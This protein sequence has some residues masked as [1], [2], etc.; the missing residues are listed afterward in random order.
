MSIPRCAYNTALGIEAE[1]NC[2]TPGTTLADAVN[3]LYFFKSAGSPNVFGLDFTKLDF[4]KGAP[5]KPVP[6]WQ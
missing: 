6:L 1:Y 4:A 2:P 5:V 3:R